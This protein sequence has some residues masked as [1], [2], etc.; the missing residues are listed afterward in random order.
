[1]NTWD[2]GTIFAALNTFV[3][4]KSPGTYIVPSAM[5]QVEGI[6]PRVASAT[7]M[8]LLFAAIH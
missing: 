7:G 8:D 6:Y 5:A 4:Q 3:T 2:S 1:M